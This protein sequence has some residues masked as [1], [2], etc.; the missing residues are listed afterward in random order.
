MIGFVFPGQGTVRVGMG[1]WLRRDPVGG[2]IL[3]RAD[4]LSPEPISALCARGP[5]PR[6]VDTAH[7]QPAVTACNLAALAV[8]RAKG[9]KPDVV[10][11]HSVGE[12]SALCAAGVM[13]VDT[14]IRL[15]GARARLM[16]ALPETGGMASVLGLSVERVE[17]LAELA[18]APGEPLV[19]GL[20]NA[21]DQV[22]VSG[23]FAAIER[24]TAAAGE[25]RKIVALK[26]SNA[27]HSPLMAG[28]V[29][30]WAEAVRSAPLRPPEIP[31]IPNVTAEPTTDLATIV[32]AL[33][34]QLTGRVLW[35]RTMRELAVAEHCVEVGDSKA[36]S[37]M[38]RTEGVRCV[39]MAAPTALRTLAALVAT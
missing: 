1:G 2:A 26:V 8:L 19:V 31:V 18:A 14:T 30:G 5:L 23:S 7:A 35:S 36:L 10:A 21:A 33:I 4:E 11:G 17:Q 6:L 38:L 12:L 22:V 39:S 13:D 25:A 29:D 32:D 15:V 34:E 24:F 37:G 28:A 9:H 16:S 27:F 20:E 3:R